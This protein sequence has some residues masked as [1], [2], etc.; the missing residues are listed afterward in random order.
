MDTYDRLQREDLMQAAV[1]IATFAYQAAMRDERLPRKPQPPVAEPV[2]APALKPVKKGQGTKPEAKPAAAPAVE[3]VPRPAAAAS[4]AASET[5]G[6]GRPA[7]G[8]SRVPCRVA[9][10]RP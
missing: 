6:R 5:C 8:R 1:V 7:A 2:T 3:A 10:V 9:S 4:G